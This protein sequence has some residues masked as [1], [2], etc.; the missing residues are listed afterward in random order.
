MGMFISPDAREPISDELGNTVWIRQGM[1][2]AMQQEYM[3]TLIKISPPS[4]PKKTKKRS[5]MLKRGQTRAD[6]IAAR[7]AAQDDADVAGMTTI[8]LGRARMKLLELNILAWDGPAFIDYDG[9]A[10]PCTPAM[11]QQLNPQEPLIIAVLERIE[12][13]N[14]PQELPDGEEADEIDAHG[15]EIV[16]GNARSGSTGDTAEALPVLEAAT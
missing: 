8:Q 5:K 2:M 11:I 15:G 6:I 14:R 7:E 10:V 3:D 16:E 12:E 4:E 9:K 13:L 1:G